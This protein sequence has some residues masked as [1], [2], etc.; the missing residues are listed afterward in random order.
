MKRQKIRSDSLENF[1]YLR[2]RIRLKKG[3]NSQKI[4]AFISADILLYKMRNQN[5]VSF[6][7]KYTQHKVPETILRTNNVKY[8]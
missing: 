5:F 1:P 6:L 7:E 2:R 4:C 3:L 8:L